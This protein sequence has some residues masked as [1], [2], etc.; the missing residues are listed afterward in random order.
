MYPTATFITFISIIYYIYII[1]VLDA[2]A[3]GVQNTQRIMTKHKMQVDEALKILH[4][5]KNE[6]NRLKIE[7]QYTRYFGQND[8]EKGGSFYIQSKVHRAK[9]A[10]NTALE[11]IEV[12]K[13]KEAKNVA[14]A[15]SNDSDSDSSNNNSSSSNSSSSSSSNSGGSSSSSSNND[16]SKKDTSQ[17]GTPKRKNSS[18]K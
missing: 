15:T 8:P 10:L 1:V 2:K 14:K 6:M 9:E 11:E 12:E 17:Y 5:D 16:N 13:E 4:I 18:S 7:A 3:G